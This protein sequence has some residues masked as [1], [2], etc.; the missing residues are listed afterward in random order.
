VT[1][2]RFNPGLFTAL[3]LLPVV[4]LLQIALA[5]HFSI[6]G[7]LPGLMLVAVV[8]WGILRG[9]EEGMIWAFIGG[10]FVDA[11]AGWPFGT[12]TVALVLVTFAVSLG[13]GTFIRTHA[14]LPLATVFGATILYY[15]VAFFVLTSTHTDVSWL[16]ALRSIVLPAA[17]YN[18][19]LNIPGFWLSQKL[20]RRVY[21]TPR[22][23]W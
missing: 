2:R 7:A 9:V 19:I 6:R 1:A 15:S 21:P 4:A 5:P 10:I 18:S 16:A 17:V 11:L 23:H 20:E 13:Q 3:W 12:S 8:N 22:A 14:L